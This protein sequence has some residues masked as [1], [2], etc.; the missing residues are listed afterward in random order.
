[1]SKR[2]RLSSL[3]LL[4]PAAE[5]DVQWAFAQL[6]ERKQTQDDIRDQLNLRLKLKGLAEISKSAFNRAAIRTARMAHRLGEV[7]EIAAVLGDKFEAGSSEELTVMVSET[8]KTVIFEM[9]ENA[10][11]LRATP[12]MAEMVANLGS[13]LKS[14][15]GAKKVSA[16]TKKLVRDNFQKQ[17]EK[18]IEKVS[19]LKGF[20]P[21]MQRRLRAELFGKVLPP[22]VK[23]Q[24]AKPE[25]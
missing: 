4:P 24:P 3:D 9:L 10:G 8:I 20:T 21:E 22:D 18:A 19:T 23:D 25:G 13:A 15:E 2:G 17:A 5:E 14:V 11:T 6:R 1:M 7:R 16:E 12:L